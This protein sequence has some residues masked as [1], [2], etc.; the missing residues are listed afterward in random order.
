MRRE[1]AVVASEADQA[2]SSTIPSGETYVLPECSAHNGV[3][4]CVHMCVCVGIG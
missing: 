2:V 3:Y 4:A 1:H